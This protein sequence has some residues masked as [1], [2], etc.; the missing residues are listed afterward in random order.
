MDDVLKHDKRPPVLY[1]RE[2]NQEGTA[3]IVDY[4]HDAPMGLTF[5]AYMTSAIEYHLGPFIA[6]GRPE[7][8][9]TPPGA[10]RHYSGDEDWQLQ[11][12]RLA[13]R[14]QALIMLPSTADQLSWEITWLLSQGLA[15]KLFIVFGPIAF[16]GL[17]RPSVSASMAGWWQPLK[18]QEL[19]ARMQFIG[20]TLP[21]KVL[22]SSV[23]GFDANGHATVLTQGA[24]SPGD[25]VIAI[26][27][28][29]ASAPR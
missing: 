19:R 4:S 26:N 18:W 15:N 16:G 5:E 2:F 14:A 1:L 25:Y 17:Y 7:D 24:C 20:Y 28:H 22:P 23:L 21:H 3:F 6:L 13:L 29:K 11:F 8:Y 9:F 12:A 27:R 10:A